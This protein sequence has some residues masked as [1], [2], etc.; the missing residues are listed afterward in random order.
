MN[1]TS[2]PQS[3]Q[4]DLVA[5]KLA[6]RSHFYIWANDMSTV[7]IQFKIEEN[8]YDFFDVLNVFRIMPSST[9]DK[10]YYE[11]WNLHKIFNNVWAFSVGSSK[12][13]FTNIFIICIYKFKFF[14]LLHNYT[15]WSNEISMGK[16]ARDTIHI[17]AWHHKILVEYEKNYFLFIRTIYSI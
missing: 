17:N 13:L 11:E 16:M 10:Y 5:R 3:S 4:A 7:K 15:L 9:S 6:S 2:L 14:F 8:S 12:N 1:V